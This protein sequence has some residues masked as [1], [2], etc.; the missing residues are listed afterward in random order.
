MDH[1]LLVQLLLPWGRD[2]SAGLSSSCFTLKIT[3]NHQ[4]EWDFG[5]I[6]LDSLCQ[7]MSKEL[8]LLGHHLLIPA[9]AQWVRSGYRGQATQ[10]LLEGSIQKSLPFFQREKTTHFL[11]ATVAHLI[12]FVLQCFSW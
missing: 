1:V 11:P 8:L 4:A 3:A 2:Q 12:I 9:L 5:G 7:L 10:S 6:F